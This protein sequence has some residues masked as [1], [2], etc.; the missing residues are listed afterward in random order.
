MIGLSLYP[1]SE[2][3]RGVDFFF[4]SLKIGGRMRRNTIREEEAA[5]AA[6]PLGKISDESRAETCGA[7][8]E[9]RPLDL[10]IGTQRLCGFCVVA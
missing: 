3:T 5:A 2:E 6:K 4:L 9:R 10:T 8:P 7:K 1:E